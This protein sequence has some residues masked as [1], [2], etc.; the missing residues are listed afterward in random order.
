MNS[1]SAIESNINELKYGAE[2][3][4][5]DKELVGFKRYLGYGVLAYNLKN[6]VNYSWANK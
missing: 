4:V 5:P 3:K 2:N 6:Q 1:H